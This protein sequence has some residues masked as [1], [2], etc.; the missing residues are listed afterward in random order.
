MDNIEIFSREL[1]LRHYT[2][3][4]VQTYTSCLKVFG[5]KI[6]WHPSLE[7]IKNYLLTINNYSYHKQMVG[8]IHRYFDFVLK[9]KISLEDI[10]YPRREYKL[11]EILSVSEV[12]KIFDEIKN[13]KHLAILSLLYGCGLR[14][15]ELLNLKISEVDSSR[16]LINVRQG[17]GLKDRQIMLQEP[18]LG[19]LRKYYKDYKPKQF[20]FNG[21]LGIQ[22]TSSSVNKLLKYYAHKAGIKKRVH[23]HKIRH[24]FATHLLEAGTELLLIKKLLGHQNIKSTEIYTHISSAFISKVNS[25]LNHIRL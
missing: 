19:L 17:K 18:L 12:Q 7:E 6:G 21:L 8:T 23:A 24:C 2:I 16:M 22:Y 5:Y 14:M 1:M 3:S 9:E 4:T 11:P 20:L 25:P 13:L 10:P 15:N